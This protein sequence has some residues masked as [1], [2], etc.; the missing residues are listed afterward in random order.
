MSRRPSASALPPPPT[1]IGVDLLGLDEHLNGPPTS[2]PPSTAST[3]QIGMTPT[4]SSDR[5]FDGGEELGTEK[6][7]DF[8]PPSSNAS[9]SS[10]LQQVREGY[11]E[12]AKWKTA[13]AA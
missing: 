2:N 8:E 3:P 10:N 7:K 4:T 5:L 11:E 12:G 9:S 13:N 1:D 6:G